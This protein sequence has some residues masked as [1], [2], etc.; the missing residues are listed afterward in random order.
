MQRRG[1]DLP[2]IPQCKE[3]T[4]VDEGEQPLHPRFRG[5]AWVACLRQKGRLLFPHQGVLRKEK[6]WQ[7]RGQKGGRRCLPEGL[8]LSREHPPWL[9][10]VARI[11]VVS[12]IR[13]LSRNSKLQGSKRHEEW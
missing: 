10:R 7:S 9:G 12:S 8:G 3:R 11:L 13:R 5:L 2:P 1:H 6:L 4:A